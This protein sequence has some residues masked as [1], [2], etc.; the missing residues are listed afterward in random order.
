MW[1]CKAQNKRQQWAFN[2]A[3]QQIKSKNGYCLDARQRMT[4]GGHVHLWTCEN[5]SKNQQ[6]QR[7]IGDPIHDFYGQKQDYSK[8]YFATG[9][10]DGQ[11]LTPF[12]MI[13]EYCQPL[14]GY[15]FDGAVDGI[16]F[17][18]YRTVVKVLYPNGVYFYGYVQKTCEGYVDFASY[19]G[20]SDGNIN[21]V[22]FAHINDKIVFDNGF[23][24][25][26]SETADHVFGYKR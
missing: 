20:E 1:P 16:R 18:V 10:W 7:L 22:H 23:T 24:F 8:N 15:Y 2:E 6:W 11:Y 9:N 3:T 14:N 4:V 12:G 5:G 21:F 13:G 26:R 17:S 19:G 25:T